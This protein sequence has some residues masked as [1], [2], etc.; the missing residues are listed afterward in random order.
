MNI[1]V[2]DGQGGGLGKALVSAIKK[3]I[4]SAH[5]YA[6][7]TNSIATSSMIKAGAD[8]A[9]TGENPVVVMS[10]KADVIVG[11]IAMVIA[12]SLMGEVTSAMANA[13]ASSDAVK[14]MIPFNHCSNIIVGVSSFSTAKMVELAIEEI[15]LAV[16]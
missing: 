8:D 6:I 13:I 15:K 1:L 4:E 16:K 7:G 10:K 11:P 3:E 2:I 5:V 14:I 12:D 9:A